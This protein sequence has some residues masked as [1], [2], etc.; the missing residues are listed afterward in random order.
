[1]KDFSQGAQEIKWK[2]AGH[3]VTVDHSPW[4]HAGMIWD[5][6]SRRKNQLEQLL[7]AGTTRK[8]QTQTYGPE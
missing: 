7:N 8:K 5:A 3:V 4:T 2:W 1:M 6:E